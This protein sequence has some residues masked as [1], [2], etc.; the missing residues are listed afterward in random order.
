MAFTVSYVGAKGAKFPPIL[1]LTPT[2]NNIVNFKIDEKEDKKVFHFFTVGQ[3]PIVEVAKVTLKDGKPTDSKPIG[4]IVLYDKGDNLDVK[5]NP[6]TQTTIKSPLDAAQNIELEFVP[7]A[8]TAFPDLTVARVIAY[9]SI[10]DES[11]KD[12]APVE[13]EVNPSILKIENNIAKISL[14]VAEEKVAYY[15][16][17][18]EKASNKSKELKFYF[19]FKTLP[20][21]SKLPDI[22]KISLKMVL[23]S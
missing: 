8:V 13:V 9:A 14:S 2:S 12:V 5:V 19:K 20:E 18:M 16:N 22:T 4:N 3:H 21:K 11:T 10:D 7:N 6:T 15:L 17:M 1:S 23:S